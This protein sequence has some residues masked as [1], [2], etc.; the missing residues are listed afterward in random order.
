MLN[1]QTSPSFFLLMLT[2][3]IWHQIFITISYVCDPVLH[4]SSFNISSLQNNID[5]NLEDQFLII[6]YSSK[7]LA[8]EFTEMKS[9]VK[10]KY[11]EYTK[12]SSD[13][14]EIK[15]VLTQMLSQKHKFLTIQYGL[16]KGLGSFH[17]SHGQ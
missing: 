8:S 5:K 13:M 7:K 15:T 11:S 16:S 1:T 2:C 9:D 17:F 3:T 10:K 6:Q 14:N 4:T 12:M